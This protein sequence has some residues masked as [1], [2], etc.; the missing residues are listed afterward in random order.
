MNSSVTNEFSI[1]FN[2]TKN[3]HKQLENKVVVFTLELHSAQ[4]SFHKIVKV[5]IILRYSSVTC[6][7][8]Q[9]NCRGWRRKSKGNV[10]A[11]WHIK[12]KV[13]PIIADNKMSIYLK[14]IVRFTTLLCIRWYD[15]NIIYGI[16]K[17]RLKHPE[18]FFAQSRENKDKK[19]VL[20]CFLATEI[21]ATNIFF[22]ASICIK[23]FMT[24]P[25]DKQSYSHPYGVTKT[26]TPLNGE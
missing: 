15:F 12:K 18:T 26:V 16:N 2:G 6:N 5:D 24:D 4:I 10:I 8:N 19:T 11:V 13:V 21:I 14:Y 20:F 25:R 9:Q 17:H 22:S 7:A 1:H 3:R 23:H